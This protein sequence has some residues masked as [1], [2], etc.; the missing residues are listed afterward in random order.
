MKTLDKDKIVQIYSII[1]NISLKFI[2]L[3]LKNYEK[4]EKYW[5]GLINDPIKYL[6]YKLVNNKYILESYVS[7]K[8]IIYY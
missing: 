5:Y 7:F 4:K 2:N 3:K 1:Y 6:N 8:K